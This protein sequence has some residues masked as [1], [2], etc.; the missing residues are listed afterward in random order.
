PRWGAEKII[1]VLRREFPDLQ[2]EQI[3]DEKSFAQALKRNDFH[4]VV[5]DYRLRWANGLAI[6]RAVKSRWPDRPVV[7]FTGTGSEEI[8]VEAMKAGLDDYVLKSPKHLARLPAAVRSVMEKAQQRRALVETEVQYRS[9]FEGVPVGLYRTS[10]DGQILDANPALVE[11]LGYP[12]RESLLAVSVTDLYANPE[13]RRQ[14]EVLL[15]QEGVV[16]DFETQLR[17]CDGGVIW[18]RDSARAVRNEQGR[19][20]Y[21]EGSLEDITEHKRAEAALRA[22]ERYL[23]LLNDITRAALETPDLRTMLQIL[24]D[25][26]AEVIDADGCY[27]TLWDEATQT[28]IPAAAYGPLRESYP[29]PRSDPGELTMTESVLRAGHPLVAEDVFHSS[30]LSPRIAA[31]YPARSLLGLPLIAGDQK[32]GA[33]LI[34]FNSLHHFTPDE[35][36]R[37]EQAAAQVALA[38]A[39]ARLL[40]KAQTHA[41]LMARLAFL[42][43]SLNRPFTVR[44]VVAA[45]GQGALTLCN[46]DRAAVYLRNPDD[47]VSCA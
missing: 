24:A 30:Y 28:T 11:M 14:E 47:T 7:M 18:V 2:V 1:T 38:V 23:T 4:L 15:E 19:V 35:I 20:R 9:L 10:P 29:R 3:T 40:E 39:K 45:I 12:S 46:A 25:R 17:R 31:R 36:A 34:A 8:A 5:T 33:V 16:R 27:I 41:E 43:G 26:L 37:G 42:S 44:E 6:L 21:Y 32:L 22:R 13:D